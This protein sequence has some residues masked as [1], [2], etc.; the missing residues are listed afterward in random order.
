MCIIF[1][2]KAI[3][4][5]FVQ[6]QHSDRIMRLQDKIVFIN[7]KAKYKHLF[8]GHESTHEYVFVKVKDLFILNLQKFD[9][10]AA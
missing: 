8:T 9:L 5:S 4:W 3:I 7:I 2:I 10:N 6:V 1:T